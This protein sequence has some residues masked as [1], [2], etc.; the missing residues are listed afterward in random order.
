MD[1]A[2]IVGM[3]LAFV[4]VILGILKGGSLLL[5]WNAPSVLIVLGGT[6]GATLINYPLKEVLGMATVV[7]N[8]FLH[9]VRSPHEMIGRLVDLSRRT[10]RGGILSLEPYV[11]GI[12]DDLFL[13]HGLQMLVDGTDMDTLRSVLE[14]DII[15][16][17][18]RHKIGADI[19]LTL[20]TYAPSLGMIGTLIGLVQMLEKLNDPSQIGPGMA[21]ALLTTFY[22]AIL[23]YLIFLPISGKLRA[24]SKQEMLLKGL[25]VEGICMIAAGENPRIVESRLQVFLAPQERDRP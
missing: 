9:T 4:L 24:R 13:K 17:S 10:R 23:A 16:A 11:K 2:T 7:K 15:Y 25:V 8:V 21:V 6:F 18:E 12:E 5:F 22:G 1:I 3:I 20:A 19:F 14:R